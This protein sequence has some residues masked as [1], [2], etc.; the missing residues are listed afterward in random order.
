MGRMVKRH[1]KYT[2]TAHCSSLPSKTVRTKQPT[3]PSR[4][5][6]LDRSVETRRKRSTYFIGG[7]GHLG[8]AAGRLLTPA[9]NRVDRV[10][11]S[12]VR[13]KHRWGLCSSGGAAA[14]SDALSRVQ[15]VYSPE[16][17]FVREMM[18]RTVIAMTMVQDATSVTSRKVRHYRTVNPRSLIDLIWLRRVDER[19]IL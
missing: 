1:I 11:S 18:T 7:G 2:S 14:S 12:E 9:V 6:T 17:R 10:R 16:D 4:T 13:K 3:W 15:T 5:D 8:R 19:K